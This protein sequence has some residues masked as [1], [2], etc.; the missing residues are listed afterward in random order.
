MHLQTGSPVAFII[1]FIGGVAASFTPCVY[2]L[3]PVTITFIGVKAEGSKKKAFFLSLFY[4]LGIAI[5]YSLLGVVASLSGRLFG[6]WQNNPL[7]YLLLGNICILLGFNVLEVFALP[8]PQFI[9]KLPEV[10]SGFM[11]SFL[12]GLAAGFV[13]GPCTTPVLGVL[14]AFVAAKQN[15]IFGILLLFIFSLGLNAL[16]VLAGTFSG[17]LSSL[18]KSGVWLQRVKKLMGW[19]L[20]LIGEYF[21]VQM[22][23]MLV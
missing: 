22:G 7:V 15:V 11:G 17:I 9:K 18:P 4:A 19:G 14:L 6:Q 20:I 3:I 23:K 16:L 1:V 13:M 12:M 5:T 21:L 8:L 2:P 10:K